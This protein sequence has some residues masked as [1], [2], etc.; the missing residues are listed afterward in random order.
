MEICTYVRVTSQPAEVIINT[1]QLIRSAHKGCLTPRRTLFHPPAHRCR[2]RGSSPFLLLYNPSKCISTHTLHPV[3]VLA[4]A[5]G[6]RRV[7]G[8]SAYSGSDSSGAA[9]HFGLCDVIGLFSQT[10]FFIS[11]SRARALRTVINGTLS[12][13]GNLSL[14]LFLSFV[15]QGKESLP[16]FASR[17]YSFHSA[18]LPQLS[19]FCQQYRVRL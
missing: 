4:R 14:S 16:C 19:A 12:Q 13:E 9:S 5:P 10:E 11:R 3:T 1:T 17:C 2:Q 7:S 6:F 18:H 15:N 8:L